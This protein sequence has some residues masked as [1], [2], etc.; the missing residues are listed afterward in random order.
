MGSDTDNDGR[1]DWMRREG[2]AA[3][4]EEHDADR[5]CLGEEAWDEVVEVGSLDGGVTTTVNILTDDSR[6]QI[7]RRRQ[8]SGSLSQSHNWKR[9]RG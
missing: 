8:V 1:S 9:V 5:E 3:D 7:R 2:N 6:T 4:M